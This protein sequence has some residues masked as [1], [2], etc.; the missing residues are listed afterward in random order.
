VDAARHPDGRYSCTTVW[1]SPEKNIGVF[2]LS[3]G[4]GLVYTYFHYTYFRD[5]REAI[6]QWYFTAIDFRTG[7]TVYKVRAGAG[8]GCSNWAGALFFASR[9]DIAYTTTIF[10]LVMLRDTVR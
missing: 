7:T 1:T 5:E 8:Q 10:G 3:F 9:R 2:K 4:S 6:T